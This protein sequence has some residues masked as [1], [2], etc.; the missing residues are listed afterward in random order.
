M[1]WLSIIEFF[2]YFLLKELCRRHKK[3]MQFKMESHKKKEIY[4]DG[5]TVGWLALG[6][7]GLFLVWIGVSFSAGFP[8]LLLFSFLLNEVYLGWPSSP[9]TPV[10]LLQCSTSH[11]GKDLFKTSSFCISLC[12]LLKGHLLSECPFSQTLSAPNS[13][14]RMCQSFTVSVPLDSEM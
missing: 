12:M 2:V 1:L 4:A 13:R 8:C 11:K 3:D 7:M 6:L 9:F 5:S 14:H 10:N